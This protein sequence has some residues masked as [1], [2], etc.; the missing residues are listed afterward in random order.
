MCQGRCAGCGETGSHH[1]V[2]SHQLQCARFAE[3]YRRDPDAIGTVQEEYDRWVAEG[4]P[5]AK[6]AAHAAVVVDTD[7]RRAAMAARFATTDI[8]ED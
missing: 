8:L 4:K 2:Q 5:A 3:L 7:T 1:R 6:A